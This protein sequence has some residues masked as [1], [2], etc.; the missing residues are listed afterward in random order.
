MSSINRHHDIQDRRPSRAQLLIRRLW[1]A[2][3]TKEGRSLTNQELSTYLNLSDS[4]LSDWAGGRTEL[5]QIEAVLRMCE[6]LGPAGFAEIFQQHL[7][8]YP[9]LRSTE[10]AHDP[11]SVAL[12]RTLSNKPSGLS[13]ILGGNPTQRTCLFCALANSFLEEGGGSRVL[14]GWDVHPASW[15]VPL[16]G[17][18]YLRDNNVEPPMLR[19]DGLPNR[20][21]LSNGL[22]ARFKKHRSHLIHC[23]I[24][25]H[26]VVADAL[27][28][29]RLPEQIADVNLPVNIIKIGDNPHRLDISLNTLPKLARAS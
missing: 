24:D 8:V 23:A 3:E 20:L 10:L 9:T 19:V 26:V 22:W 29:G 4:A 1:T 17:L 5:N 2:L 11:A 21:I 14:V 28:A 6:R 27:D 15:F 25:H 12:L 7:R 13:F 16:P 18:L